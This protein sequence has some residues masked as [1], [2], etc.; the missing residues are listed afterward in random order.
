MKWQSVAAIL[1]SLLVLGGVATY[2][3]LFGALFQLSGIE[4]THSGDIV[5]GETCESYINITTSYWTIC[6]AHYEN[7]KYEEEILFKKV[8]RSRTLHVNLDKVDNI[9]STEPRVEVD[10][11]V[12]AR[13]GWRDIK[14]GDC[15]ERGK[16]NRIKLIGHKDRK[17]DVKW[18]FQTG[19]YVD[20]DP[21]W[22]GIEKISEDKTETYDVNLTRIDLSQ[23]GGK[24]ITQ[25][26]ID[27][28]YPCYLQSDASVKCDVIEVSKLTELNKKAD[29]SKG[30]PFTDYRKPEFEIIQEVCDSK[31]ISKEEGCVDNKINVSNFVGYETIYLDY[32]KKRELLLD[33]TRNG[34]V[35]IG[36]ASNNFTIT[37]FVYGSCFNCSIDTTVELSNAHADADSAI[38]GW[39]QFTD[40]ATDSSG[41]GNDG[42]VAGATHV[43]E[44]FEFDG[45]ADFVEIDDSTSMD[46]IIN[47]FTVS[48]WVK[49]AM[50]YDNSFPS[51]WGH[52]MHRTG[53]QF[54]CGF[55]GW[56]DTMTFKVHNASDTM[57]VEDSIDLLKDVWYYYT[58]T[59]NSS[60]QTSLYR[61]GN[62]ITGSAGNLPNLRAGGT[63][64]ISYTT[65]KAFNG[66]IDEV[67]LY[68]RSLSA[69]EILAL[70]NK[71]LY[72]QQGN[73]TSAI[74]D[75]GEIA[76]WRQLFLGMIEPSGTNITFKTRSLNFSKANFSDPN[77]VSLWALNDSSC[78]DSVGNNDG[79]ASG[80]T[81][82]AQGNDTVFEGE[83]VTFFDG[84]NDRISISIVPDSLQL[85]NSDFTISSW[86]YNKEASSFSN[87]V[88]TKETPD[89]FGYRIELGSDD[90][91]LSIGNGSTKQ[92]K[93]TELYTD[94]LNQWTHAV[95]V[96]YCTKGGL[97]NVSFYQDGVFLENVEYTINGCVT[98]SSRKFSIGTKPLL[99][100]DFTGSLAYISIYNRSL[101]QDEILDIGEWQAC[102]LDSTHTFCNI[103]S[104][105]SRFLQWQA[106]LKT[107]TAPA[108]VT[109][110]L[111]NLTINYFDCNYN[112]GDFNIGTFCIFQNQDIAIDGDLVLWNEGTI[113]LED[114]DLDFNSTDQWI[115]FENTADEDKL[116]LNG[117]SQIN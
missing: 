50:D 6:F 26:S 43:H 77:L 68:N 94:N 44:H 96:F 11:L 71:G 51:R 76:N 106:L 7:T 95:V 49:P 9:I 109:P 97:S 30:I 45:K 56:G 15:W 37:D 22:E 61:N 114:S 1:V 27:E 55:Q 100:G 87:P 2:T 46:S 88:A 36:F 62:F 98:N 28:N 81:C 99:G 18:S 93:K 73:F 83:N 5:C 20:I 10:W 113:R 72:R 47:E 24:E 74:Y 80:T 102:N 82:G 57:S 48:L 66:S 41:L 12:P 33:I 16:I 40:D 91:G 79:T 67:L 101:S 89:N 116:I 90:L 13:S 112:G 29:T 69:S 63:T 31:L 110:I 14:D 25:T 75:N 21:I 23:F 52:F 35:V 54:E 64:Y 78:R 59:Y 8:A 60:N 92:L 19:E 39:W 32:S 34:E 115:I 38:V 108:N 42:T 117:T 17:Q 111:S 104:S 4:Y 58:F 105:N 3:D 103:S 107:K 84:G 65:T 70:Y 86:I 53:V 85:N